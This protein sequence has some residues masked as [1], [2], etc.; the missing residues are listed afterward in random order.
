ML[1]AYHGNIHASG[2]PSFATYLVS[3]EVSKLGI[4]QNGYKEQVQQNSMNVDPEYDD[5]R[6]ANDVSHMK[7]LL[8]SADLLE[9][10]YHWFESLIRCSSSSLHDRYKSSILTYIFYT[11]L[12]PFP[13]SHS[14]MCY[15]KIL[16]MGV[17]VIEIS[18]RM[19]AW[20]VVQPR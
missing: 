11:Y 9:G 3:G 18:Y 13:G 17:L 5:G 2:S 7:M 8:V 15:T 4:C 12:Q 19:Q 14:R 16:T 1:A 20:Y 10:V 6:H